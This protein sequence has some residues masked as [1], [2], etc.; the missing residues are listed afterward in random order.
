MIDQIKEQTDSHTV[1]CIKSL[2]V[3]SVYNQMIYYLLKSILLIVFC[4]TATTAE[5]R[6][7]IT[8]CG[9]SSRQRHWRSWTQ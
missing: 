8:N 6:M 7:A 2:L 4:V 1:S 9:T 5:T 3:A